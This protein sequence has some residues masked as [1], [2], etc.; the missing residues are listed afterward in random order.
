MKTVYPLQTKFAGGIMRNTSMGTYFISLF[1][2]GAIENNFISTVNYFIKLN[3][4]SA[5]QKKILLKDLFLEKG[6]F[7]RF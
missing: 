1:S 6:Y 3:K 2:K 7:L 5:L 4:V